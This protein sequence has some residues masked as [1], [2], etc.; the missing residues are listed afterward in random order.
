MGKKINYRKVCE[1]LEAS[2]AYYFSYN[3]VFVEELSR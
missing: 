1:V 3:A 2:V